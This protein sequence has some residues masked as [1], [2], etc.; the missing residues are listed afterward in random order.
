MIIK[1]FYLINMTF[2]RIKFNHLFIDKTFYIVLIKLIV[3]KKTFKYYLN[4]IMFFKQFDNN[5][6]FFH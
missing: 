4:P 6:L 5:Y 2:N 3:I 1:H